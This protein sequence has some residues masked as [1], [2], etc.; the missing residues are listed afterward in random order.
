VIAR[1][2]Q[3]CTSEMDEVMAVGREFAHFKSLLA[4]VVNFERRNFVQFL[5]VIDGTIEANIKR[6]T[7]YANVNRPVQYKS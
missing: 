3:I 5:G 2:I 1:I 7:R 6:N 4:A